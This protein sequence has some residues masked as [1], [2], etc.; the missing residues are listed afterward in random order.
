[1]ASRRLLTPNKTRIPESPCRGLPQVSKINTLLSEKG[2]VVREFVCAVGNARSSRLEITAHGTI[3]ASW[4]RYDDPTRR[5]L[6]ERRG[7]TW[8]FVYE[9]PAAG[10]GAGSPVDDDRARQLLA[11]ARRGKSYASAV[12]EPKLSRWW[13]QGDS[14][15][16]PLACHASALPTELWPRGDGSSGVRGARAGRAR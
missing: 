5:L 12:P 6:H 14:N 4:A 10:S 9:G 16:R 3:P 13:S 2:N 11:V 1:M 7:A 8:W 15:P